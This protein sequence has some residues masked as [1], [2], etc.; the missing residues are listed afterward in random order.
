MRQFVFAIS[1]RSSDNAE[2]EE[3]GTGALAEWE[4]TPGAVTAEWEEVGGPTLT[5]STRVLVYGWS[6]ELSSPQANL[7]MQYTF[8]SAADNNVA[9]AL[10][11]N[12]FHP[13]SSSDSND[14]QQEKT[15][16]GVWTGT[17]GRIWSVFRNDSNADLGVNF[18]ADLLTSRLSP[19]E[20]EG[21]QKMF[22]AL[23]FSD[24]YADP[25]SDGNGQLKYLINYND[26]HLRD[27]VS[28]LVTIS[29]TAEDR[30]MKKFPS[31]LGP[32]IH[33][34]VSDT[35]NSQT[36]VLLSDFFI[37]FRERFRREGR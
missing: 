28:N 4:T 29:T 5:D 26:P 21:A 11:T 22:L 3:I 10:I 16:F 15:L 35:S 34:Y 8:A 1:C 36:K 13:S 31:M 33:L 7:W 18:T 30:D 27:W 14:P 32:F 37:H 6:P 25:T 23:G 20:L 24:A 9:G 17:A 2:W 12:L 19:G